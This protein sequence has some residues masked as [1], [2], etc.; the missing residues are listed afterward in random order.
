MGITITNRGLYYLANNAIS[1]STDI[2]AGVIKGAVPS[3]ATIR[4]L[5]FVADLLAEDGVVEAAAA[6][7]SRQDLANVALTEV[8]ASDHVTLTTDGWTMTVAAGE[9]WLATF[10]FV[11]T[12][13][14]ATSLRRLR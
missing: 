8:D 6:G 12:G 5:N 4:D 10:Y 7:Y 3:A 13:D 14:N 11:H 2:R 1:G 9:T